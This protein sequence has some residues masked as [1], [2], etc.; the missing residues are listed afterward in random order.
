MLVSPKRDP[1]KKRNCLMHGSKNDTLN[2]KSFADLASPDEVALAFIE[3][4]G[5]DAHQAVDECI[6]TS[7]ADGREEDSRFWSTVAT[8]LRDP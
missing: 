2:W 7:A 1:S 4:Y 3:L 8:I 5:K 6:E